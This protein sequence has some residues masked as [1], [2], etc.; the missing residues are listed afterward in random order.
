M[1]IGENYYGRSRLMLGNRSILFRLYQ[2]MKALKSVATTIELLEIVGYFV[3][4]SWILISKTSSSGLF[5]SSLG[6][7]KEATE[8][9]A[10][11]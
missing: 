3:T 9:D 11:N 8:S 6:S 4:I 1:Y 2:I 5:E 7:C 10:I